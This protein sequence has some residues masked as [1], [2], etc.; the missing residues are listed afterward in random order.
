M[1]GAVRQRHG[2]RHAWSVVHGD[3]FTVLADLVPE[4]VDAVVCDPPYGI[5]FNGERWDGPTIRRAVAQ[6]G[7]KLTPGQAFQAWSGSGRASAYARCA[8]VRT[9][10]RSPRRGPRTVSRARSRTTG[11]SCATR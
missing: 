4:S 9:S 5:D 7:R 6:R 11:S 10:L 1:Q 2:R 3:S 8:P